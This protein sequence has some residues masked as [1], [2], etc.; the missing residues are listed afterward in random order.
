MTEKKI[1]LTK[2]EPRLE[3][4]YDKIR[5][6]E[7]NRYQISQHVTKLNKL[8]YAGAKLVFDKLG[9]PYR[10]PNKNTKPG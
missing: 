9:I 8:I 5:K 1:A 3:K 6:R 10:N 4:S 2:I 7:T